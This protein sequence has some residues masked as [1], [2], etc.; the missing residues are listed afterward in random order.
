MKFMEKVWDNLGLFEASE[1]DEEQKTNE[2]E[3]RPKRLRNQ[4]VNS[5]PNDVNNVI[6]LP[7]AAKTPLSSVPKQ[8]K[9][10]VVEPVSFD[11]VQHVAD[12]LKAKK[13]VVINL[14]N[15]DAEISRRMVDFVSGTTYALNGS[16]QK[17]SN[18]IFLC[19]PQN[20]DVAYSS[21]REE[22]QDKSMFPWDQP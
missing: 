18:Q 2:S 15:A 21:H 7:T 14:E 4:A 22:R 19:A 11:D 10:M 9:V 16:M 13:P 6:S 3:R 1:Q 8:L 17:I 12:Y 5:L 20:V